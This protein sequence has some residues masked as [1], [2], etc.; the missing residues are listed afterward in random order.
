MSQSDD[1]KYLASLKQRYKKARSKI[2][3]EYVQ[4]TGHHRK[5]AMA[6]LSGKRTRVQHPIRRPRS[7]IYGA[8]D[9]RALEALGDVFDGINSKLMRVALDNELEPLCRNGFL[10]VSPA[11]HERLKQI[12]PATMAQL[13]AQHGRRL[14]GRQSRSRTKPGTFSS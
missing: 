5:H 4:T 9:A 11:G 12:S 2:L 6:V 13:R 3:D 10:H 8:E 1:A 14:V 7:V